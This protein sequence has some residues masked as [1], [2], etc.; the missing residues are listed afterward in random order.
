MKLKSKFDKY[1]K[2]VLLFAVVMILYFLMYL[3]ADKPLARKNVRFGSETKV[4]KAVKTSKGS[5]LLSQLVIRNVSQSASSRTYQSALSISNSDLKTRLAFLNVTM[6]RTQISIE[7]TDTT[8]KHRAFLLR[9]PSNSSSISNDTS[10]IYSADVSTSLSL[11]S[12]DSLLHLKDINTSKVNV[13]HYFRCANPIGRLGNMM[14]QLASTLGLAHT[15]GYI[16]Y[17]EPSHPLNKLFDTN[18]SL[19]LNLTNVITLNEQ[20]CKDRIWTK[21]K[22]ILSHNLTAWR[23]FQSW[24]YINNNTE[25]VRKAFTIKKNYLNKAYQFI[26]ASTHANDVLVG[27]HIR[28]G[29]FKSD[30]LSG[31]GYTMADGNFT[32]KA[33]DWHRRKTANARFV[34]VSD[35]MQWCRNNIK[36]YDIV[37]SNF[38]EPIM[39]LAVL[40]L[41]YHTIITGGSFGWWG[42]WLAGGTVIYLKDFPTAGSWLEKNMP[43][44]EDYYPKNWIAMSNGMS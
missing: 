42:A 14:F 25:E 4:S 1:F 10:L 41:C 30:Y 12:N 9:R 5:S 13:T 40:S 24:K 29:D 20:Q 16:P 18:L 27:M 2:S 23:Y 33:M 15:L 31:L 38:T 21:N 35:D 26:K 6:L 37:Y 7:T 22:D 39:D 11:K 36:G 28:R 43:K 17:I 3:S 32:R 34:I 44:R 19:S 8:R